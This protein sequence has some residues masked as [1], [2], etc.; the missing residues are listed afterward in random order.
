MRERIWPLI[1]FAAALVLTFY[2]ALQA[3]FYYAITA[4]ALKEEQSIAM[5]AGGI[6]SLRALTG[7]RR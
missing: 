7:Q 6:A 5:Q 4:Q 3:T 1:I 2:I